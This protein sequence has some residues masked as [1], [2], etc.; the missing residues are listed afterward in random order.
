ML[1][2]FINN[3]LFS[4]LVLHIVGPDK[5]IIT[6]AHKIILHTNSLFFEKLLTNFTEALAKEIT[7]KVPNAVII[8]K[9]IMSYYGVTMEQPINRDLIVTYDFLMMPYEHLL[10]KISDYNELVDTIDYVGYTENRIKL[11]AEKMPVDYE[12]SSFPKELLKEIDYHQSSQLIITSGQKKNGEI[13]IWDMITNKI[14]RKITA[15]GSNNPICITSDNQKIIVGYGIY[16][17]TYE[18]STGQPIYDA[19]THAE[20]LSIAVTPNNKIIITGHSFGIIQFFDTNHASP[21][22]KVILPGNGGN[23]ISIIPISNTKF[24]A[25]DSERRINIC[26]IE[27]IASTKTA[28][29][30][31]T[32]NKHLFWTGMNSIAITSDHKKLLIGDDHATI[33]ILNAETDEII[34]TFVIHSACICDIYVTNDNKRVISSSLDKTIKIWDIDTGEIIKIFDNSNTNYTWCNIVVTCDEKKIISLCSTGDIR[35][36]D[37]ESNELINTLQDDA[38]TTIRP[39]ILANPHFRIKYLMNKN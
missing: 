13:K 16:I 38:S 34:K 28:W 39:I 6:H 15:P 12:T 32:L 21:L 33:R 19:P 11:L 9:I 10:E 7:I 1:K 23:T 26:N 29:V 3:T 2:T 20:I 36:W 17:R 30:D 4:D 14:V 24:L 5:T 31:H 35:I 8:R 27:S 25:L 22:G 18:F 37:I